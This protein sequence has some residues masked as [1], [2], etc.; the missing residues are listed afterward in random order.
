MNKIFWDTDT[1]TIVS[2][3]IE[4]DEHKHW[5]M[6]VFLS[7]EKRCEATSIENIHFVQMCNRK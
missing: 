3:Q 7:M 5:A 2:N 4:A 6:Q 1:I